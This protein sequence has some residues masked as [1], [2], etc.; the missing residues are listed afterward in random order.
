MQTKVPKMDRKRKKMIADLEGKIG[1][2]PLQIIEGKGEDEETNGDEEDKTKENELVV[3]KPKETKQ[4]KIVIVDFKVKRNMKKGDTPPTSTPQR[5]IKKKDLRKNL[6]QVSRK[7]K[8][9]KKIA[10]IVKGKFPPKRKQVTKGT[11]QSQKKKLRR[12]LVVIPSDEEDERKR[13]KLDDMRKFQIFPRKPCQDI[14]Q[15]C[16]NIRNSTRISG[17]KQ[18]KFDSLEKI[19]KEKVVQ[20]ILYMMINFKYMIIDLGKVILEEL[21]NNMDKKWK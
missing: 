10:K 4:K 8:G 14:N 19:D 9:K 1:E 18:V 7:I 3:S 17:F 13:S 16:D 11:E 20:A 21:Y 12:K 15:V 2:G 5:R 6:L